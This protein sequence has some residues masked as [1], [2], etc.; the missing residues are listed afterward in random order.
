V[1]RFILLDSG[2][3]GLACSRP[4]LLPVDRCHAWLTTLEATGAVNVIPAI[5]D[6]EVRREL[7]RLLATAK[8]RNLDGLCVRFP[9]LE[10]NRAALD[11]AAELWAM[12][13]RA[14]QP[15]AG[16]S[17]LDADAIL[18]GQAAT[19]G[20]PGDLV[21]IATT[22]ARHLARFPGIDARDWATIV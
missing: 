11:R 10:I 9:Y 4:G 5:A 6:Y 2:P 3:L 20:Q 14:G 21:I 1:R 13:R 18:A 17:D 22:N 15:T 12:V 8:L 19:L 7:I 16:P